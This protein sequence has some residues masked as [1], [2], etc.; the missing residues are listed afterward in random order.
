MLVTC[1]MLLL[2]GCKRDILKDIREQQWNH[3]RAIIDIVFENQVGTAAI[4]RDAQA[5]GNVSFMY[6]VGAGDANKLIIKNIEL[7][8]GARSSLSEG[9][10]LVFDNNHT[11]Q[12]VVT[13][14]TGQDRTWTIQYVPFTDDL[15]GTWQITTLSV[16][17]G[18]W[19]EYG[20]AAVYTDMAERSWNWR[21]DGTGPGAEYDNTLT[22]TLEGISDEGD[23]YGRIV[24]DAGADGRYADFTFIED[25]DNAPTPID[26]N[27]KYRTMPMGEGS[28]RRNSRQGTITFSGGGVVSTG[29]FVGS[30]TETLDGS[31]NQLTLQNQAFV[32]EL[33]PSFIWIDIY[34][35]REKFV[36]NAKKYWIQVKKGNQ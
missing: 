1:C 29:R 5:N 34:K 23:A 15:V 28:W 10:E 26:V 11:A 13:S 35:D 30:G 22:F 17:G 9:D 21:Q 18:A 7:S 36:E 8:Y 6:N 16:Y 24:N 27:G 33:I 4:Q 19:P 3:E 32:F 12:L 20:G 25:P 31:N 2:V 14:K